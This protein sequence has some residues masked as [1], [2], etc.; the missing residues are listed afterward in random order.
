MT[1]FT[2]EENELLLKG[3]EI[4]PEDS[5]GCSIAETNGIIGYKDV[6]TESFWKK[7]MNKTESIRRCVYDLI[8]VSS[9]TISTLFKSMNLQKISTLYVSNFLDE[10]FQPNQN[11]M[12]LSFISF[13]K[14]YKEFWSFI[15]F[16]THIIPKLK[17]L[18]KSSPELTL[19]F[20]IPI[21]GSIP[22]EEVY[23]HTSGNN[24]V[25]LDI[26][27]VDNTNINVIEEF[28]LD[29]DDRNDKKNKGKNK[30][31]NNK[32]NEKNIES[33]VIVD[34]LLP[35]N[36]CSIISDLLSY[37]VELTENNLFPENLLID[38]D[39]CISQLSIILLLRKP[40]EITNE[41]TVEQTNEILNN[42]ESLPQIISNRLIRSLSL[43]LQI[44]A[45]DE[46]KLI[47]NEHLE[48]LIQIFIQLNRGTDKEINFNKSLW[49]SL[50]W[51]KITNEILMI[52]STN[53]I[54]EFTELFHI[55]KNLKDIFYTSDCTF[56]YKLL[57]DKNSFFSIQ[58]V[59]IMNILF[60]CISYSGNNNSE[61]KKNDNN[62]SGLLYIINSIINKSCKTIALLPKL[63][64]FASRNQNLPIVLPNNLKKYI[65]S[66]NTSSNDNICSNIMNTLEGISSIDI[67]ISVFDQF[68]DNNNVN[69]IILDYSKDLLSN[70]SKWFVTITIS[71]S[72]LHTL[73]S[74]NKRIN[75]KSSLIIFIKNKITV[76]ANLIQKLIKMNQIDR[77]ENNIYF[78]NLIQGCIDGNSL[79]SLCLL[80]DSGLLFDK[81]LMLINE[82][83]INWLKA[84]LNL[85]ILSDNSNNNIENISLS[86]NL[87]SFDAKLKLLF[88]CSFIKLNENEKLIDILIKNW[89]TSKSKLSMWSLLTFICNKDL[90]FAIGVDNAINYTEMYYDYLNKINDSN[91]C[92]DILKYSFLSRIRHNHN[93]NNFSFFNR[94]D[95]KL[96][97]I[98]TW[99]NIVAFII[100]ILTNQ[101]NHAFYSMITSELVASSN[102]NT[103]NNSTDKES[104]EFED[105][106]NI[107]NNFKPRKFS[108]HLLG[109]ISLIDSNKL[110][111]ITKEMLFETIQI[112]DFKF[113]DVII[114]IISQPIVDINELTMKLN[115][116]LQCIINITDLSSSISWC[117]IFYS[118]SML[119][120]SILTCL[121]GY[122]DRISLKSVTSL[123]RLISTPLLTEM[124]NRVLVICLNSFKL[125]S[126]SIQYDCITNI[127]NSSQQQQQQQNKDIH[128]WYQNMIVMLLNCIATRN[129]DSNLLVVDSLLNSTSDVNSPDIN[130]SRGLDSNDN[131]VC[132][133]YL[134]DTPIHNDMIEIGSTVWY[135]NNNNNNS[136]ND[137]DLVVVENFSLIEGILL[138]VHRE[139]PTEPWYTI[140]L[141]ELDKE[142]QT[143]GCRLLLSQPCEISNNINSID[144]G[145]SSDISSIISYVCQ[146]VLNSITNKDNE[147]YKLLVS[148]QREMILLLLNF[149]C[150]T[151]DKSYDN[152][153]VDITNLINK[154]CKVCKDEI[155]L[156]LTKDSVKN[157]SDYMYGL[158]LFN[159]MISNRISIGN[160]IW[161]PSI[162]KLIKKGYEIYLSKAKIVLTKSEKEYFIMNLCKTFSCIL[163]KLQWKYCKLFV[164]DFIAVPMGLLPSENNLLSSSI[165]HC[166]CGIWKDRI[167]NESNKK[168]ENLSGSPK[169]K[170]LS[171]LSPSSLAALNR[172]NN[173][174]RSTVLPWEVQLFDFLLFI[175]ANGLKG[176]GDMIKNTAGI[177]INYA[178]SGRN[179]EFSTKLIRESIFDNIHD[180][181]IKLV[182]GVA[183]NDTCNNS[184]YSNVYI[185]SIRLIACKL[186]DVGY[187]DFISAKIT[188]DEILTLTS[189]ESKNISDKLSHIDD[190]ISI[191]N[192]NE[193]SSVNE[194]DAN[195]LYID[196]LI[197]DKAVGVDLSIRVKNMF[198]NYHSVKNIKNYNKLMKSNSNDTFESIDVDSI[199][200]DEENID[201]DIKE[202][203]DADIYADEVNNEFD[204]NKDLT[205]KVPIEKSNITSTSM[206]IT[207]SN[208]NDLVSILYSWLLVLQ[209]IDTVAS[210]NWRVRAR[211]GSYL[212]KIKIIDKILSLL[213]KSTPNDILLYN[214][215]STALQRL[216]YTPYKDMNEFTQQLVVY[217][218][219]RTVSLIL[220]N[221]IYIYIYINIHIFFFLKVCVLPAIVR[222]WWSH[223]C[224]RGQKV[225]LTKFIE[226]R[227]KISLIK[228][229]IGLIELA[230]NQER[231]NESDFTVSCSL[232]GE[233]CAVLIQEDTKIEMKIKL[234]S[235][236]PLKVC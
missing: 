97:L 202:D 73:L 99:D 122:I 193:S 24:Y 32:K 161:I 147:E 182:K 100:P 74:T 143:E 34:I 194:A 139:I 224:S 55:D 210:H 229:E 175:F 104:N 186:L 201:T 236:Y 69:S 233:I 39:L 108:R 31:K 111:T 66:N 54:N 127:I 120:T 28:S 10:L 46:E 89:Q 204:S 78:D 138:A 112:G 167:N 47:N 221:L 214:N 8:T 5:I 110:H 17:K 228:R 217:V 82:K 130:L 129:T 168:D 50:I 63:K 29:M 67:L 79:E 52:I 81:N 163:D 37:L 223:S 3:V 71:Y 133:R 159:I 48:S 174:V 103:L 1:S 96:N 180:E 106:D 22:A 113:W 136:N 235:S 208:S 109:L 187:S 232:A 144:S 158:T 155:F 142:I 19:Q 77:I 18:L 123:P 101:Q 132:Y 75:E 4:L 49:N 40:V 38:A 83:C 140:R 215:L 164:I 213:M 87:C 62:I 166:I 162:F 205:L 85:M 26:S 160:L 2:S 137:S 185:H 225:K 115:Y 102:N 42:M 220:K 179:R 107:E 58:L 12:F 219:Y 135:I 43:L 176:H 45:K 148:N 20:L 116:I 86:V 212:G 209:K 170:Q 80:F 6:I 91:T 98:S 16:D 27:N 150:F 119:C 181:L 121:F 53:Y 88:Y 149:V 118:N 165:L 57:M 226:E 171:S 105:N 216:N 76:V 153:D 134:I 196:G 64:S 36:N 207:L 70:I 128:K 191:S 51:N 84:C 218:L 231:W 126:F 72:K 35:R 30:C 183:T 41:I 195:E 152:S 93:N 198:Q 227:V 156:L 15:N 68:N 188:S 197:F 206:S 114:L 199:S 141:I 178:L 203:F 190:D 230:K 33:T 234:P 154:V 60:K 56:E 117:E 92:I 200:I 146:Y 145:G 157:A 11:S 13:I 172:Y 94:N 23:I 211:C 192:D 9:S 7:T 21:I 189:E 125:C 14:N 184:I 173:T 61:F 131:G 222:N 65:G 25:D 169:K 95:S 90:N 44:F 59:N 124:I 151:Y 177:G